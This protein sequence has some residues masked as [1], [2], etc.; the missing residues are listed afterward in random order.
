MELIIFFNTVLYSLHSAL[1]KSMSYMPYLPPKPTPSQYSWTESF[2]SLTIGKS[3]QRH[4]L[5]V[6]P[7]HNF[8]DT[9]K[10]LQFNAYKV[11]K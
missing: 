1:T 11:K 7:G 3:S 6:K 4:R 5:V 2:L 10:N 8:Y 9:S